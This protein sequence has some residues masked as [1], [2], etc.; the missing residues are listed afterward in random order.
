MT[1]LDASVV[2]LFV[3]SRV[4]LSHPPLVLYAFTNKNKLAKKSKW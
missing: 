3:C 1:Y 4:F 2:D